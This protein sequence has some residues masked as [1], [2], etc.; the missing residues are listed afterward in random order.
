M[1]TTIYILI[2][3]EFLLTTFNTFNMKQE[4][5]TT[6]ITPNLSQNTQSFLRPDLLQPQTN[7]LHVFANKNLEQMIK[8]GENSKFNII[9]ELNVKSNTNEKTIRRYSIIH[10]N[11]GSWIP[12]PTYELA[13]NDYYFDRST[14]ELT[15]SN[16][17]IYEDLD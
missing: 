12:I 17:I 7:D 2:L 13:M 4:E 6:N 9:V 11:T 3:S 14:Q 10:K 15:N 8:I 1:K 16:P 5:D